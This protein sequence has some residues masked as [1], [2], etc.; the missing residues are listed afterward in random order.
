V[1]AFGLSPTASPSVANNSAASLASQRLSREDREMQRIMQQFQQMEQQNL[2]PASNASPAVPPKVSLVTTTNARK[3]K[4]D[5]GK[6]KTPR[7]TPRAAYVSVLDIMIELLLIST[8]YWCLCYQYGWRRSA[9]CDSATTITAAAASHCTAC[10][11][12]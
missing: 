2:P 8:R 12:C 4:E 5:D 11:V 6:N 9:S 7:A 1:V 3:R 10:Q